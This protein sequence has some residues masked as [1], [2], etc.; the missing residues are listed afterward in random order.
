MGS[1]GERVE[2]REYIKQIEETGEPIREYKLLSPLQ[3]ARAT[4]LEENPEEDDESLQLEILAFALREENDGS[5]TE[6][7]TSFGPMI[8]TQQEDGQAEE[9]PGR[10][11]VTTEAIEYWRGRAKESSHPVLRGKYAR[12]AWDLAQMVP[13]CKPDYVMAQISIDSAI[14]A[15]VG[16]HLESPL[17]GIE[18]LATALRIAHTINDTDRI[19]SVRDEMIRYEQR[20]AEDE[21]VGLWGF[22]FDCL[23]EDGLGNPTVEQ[24]EMLVKQLEDRLSRLASRDPEQL[25][26]W[27]VEAAAQRLA[28]YYRRTGSADEL[29]RVLSTLGTAFENRAS[30]VEPML[31]YALLEHIHGVFASFGLTEEANRISVKLEEIGPALRASLKK[32]TVETSI[33]GTKIREA[34]ESIVDYEPHEALERLA[35]SFVPLRERVERQV[36]DYANKFVLG[37]LCMT[38]IKDYAGRTVSQ[39]G[40]VDDDLEG[41]IVHQMSQNLQFQ[42]FLLREV[43][44]EAV[45][46]NIFTAE[47]VTS[48]LFESPV[49]RVQFREIISHGVGM[50]LDND[51][52]GAIHLLVPQVECAVRGLLAKARVQ[53]IR[54]LRHGGGFDLRLLDDMLRDAAT[55]TILGEDLSLYL[56]VLLT[57]RRGW[58]I[59][60]RLCHAD[61]PSAEM[62]DAL[63]DR[64][65]H[66][67]LCMA[68][69]REK[70][71]SDSES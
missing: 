48:F 13:Q 32:I 4:M 60:N 33:E 16:S 38:D 58:N 19:A 66:A 55:K 11:M 64:A 27:K 37:N 20:V 67:L 42:G 21:K 6:W 52:L 54:P 51:P 44:S 15:S 35:V 17:Q 25:D 29:T 23:L 12:L 1:P 7:G 24:V 63:A 65:V 31:A 10:T 69:V 68:L 39:I 9:W 3:K 28:G 26:P 36:R 46:R 59:R 30:R 8:T 2:W 43:L 47:N 34:V 18:A 57:D 41:R 49:F 53:T 71:K 45:R 56:R 14:E 5:A 61:L 40:S 62:G 70:P 50:F 22:S